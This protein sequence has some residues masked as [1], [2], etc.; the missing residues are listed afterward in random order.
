MINT[1]P[2]P[3][4]NALFMQQP[5]LSSL[6]QLS[7]P[8]IAKFEGK[9]EASPKPWRVTPP[10]KKRKVHLETDPD[11][12]K[13]SPVK[14]K[15]T[16]AK[17]ATTCH[18]KKKHSV[19]FSKL[20]K[21]RTLQLER[22]RLSPEAHHAM[23][24]SQREY[25]EMEQDCYKNLHAFHHVHG[26]IARLPASE[27]CVRGLEM[28]T[29]PH[30]NRLRRLRASITVRAILDQQDY[31]RRKVGKGCD[32]VGESMAMASRRYTQRAQIRARELGLIDAIE[33]QR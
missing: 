23:W 4:S 3:H 33:A 12:I 14:V 18:K 10:L 6:Q 15:K 19:R 21:V 7:L 9:I 31:L 30:I 17:F 24:Y 11:A 2:L 16:I 32:L 26:D 29:S 13:L 22:S 20:C 27:Y 8:L 25:A 28:K 1:L 5:V